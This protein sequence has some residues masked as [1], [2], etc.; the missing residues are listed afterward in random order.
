MVGRET[1]LPIHSSIIVVGINTLGKV[2]APYRQRSSFFVV[3]EKRLKECEPV[4]AWGVG[5]KEGKKGAR[6]RDGNK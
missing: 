6:G 1:T 2:K 4:F 3:A 5:G